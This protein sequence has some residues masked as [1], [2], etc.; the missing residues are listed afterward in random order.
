MWA[1][2]CT[3]AWIWVGFFTLALQSAI[4]TS[5]TAAAYSDFATAPAYT[6]AS[7]LANIIGGVIRLPIAKALNLWGRAEAFLC[8]VGVYVLGLIILASCNGVNAYAAGYVL[9]WI[10]YD[11]VYIIMD[12]FIADTSGL[13]KRAFTF[14]FAATPFICTAFTGG[15]AAQSFLDMTTWRWAIGAFCIIQPVV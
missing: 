14:A 3:Y 12:V 11:T 4:M 2:Y 1:V 9:Y 13:R 15:P 7:I 8:M 5:A 10:G 6:T